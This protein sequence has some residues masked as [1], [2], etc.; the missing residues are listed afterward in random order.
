MTL[1]NKSADEQ[2]A[3]VLDVHVLDV[4][5]QIELFLRNVREIQRFA[6]QLR[7]VTVPGP[8]LNSQQALARIE[9]RLVEMHGDCEAFR[10]A[11]QSAVE[12]LRNKPTTD[13]E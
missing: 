7:G 2:T 6:L 8:H 3:D 11:I 13:S 12:M 9:Q 1:G 10:S 4:L 5:A